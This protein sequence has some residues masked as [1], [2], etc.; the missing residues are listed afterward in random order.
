MKETPHIFQK[1]TKSRKVIGVIRTYDHARL[2][3]WLDSIGI[4][5]D[6]WISEKFNMH[7][8]AEILRGAPAGIVAGEFAFENITPD[9][10]FEVITKFLSGNGSSPDELEV[11]VHAFGDDGTSPDASDTT[12]GNETVRKLV[13]SKSYS[14]PSA[15]Y[16]VFYDLSEGNGTHAE[17]GLFANADAGTPDD[18]T[19]WDHSLISITKANTQSLTIDYEDAFVNNV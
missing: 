5:I 18:G 12:L 16:T 15:F 14:G 3:S 2:L 19:L 17:M 11:M 4:S 9:I 10:G 6:E 8:R 1:E 13:S 7:S